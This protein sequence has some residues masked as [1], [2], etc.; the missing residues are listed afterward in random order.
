MVKVKRLIVAC[1]VAFG[2]SGTV[3]IAQDHTGGHGQAGHGAGSSGSG[4]LHNHM[5]KAAGEMR[6]MPMSG[7]VDHDFVSAMRKHHQHGVEMAQ[8]ALRSAKDPEARAFAQRVVTEQKKEIAELD[9]W[10]AKHQPGAATK[11]N[12]GRRPTQ[13]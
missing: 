8:I 4:E 3:A 10:L 6:S 7:D 9:A 1:S 2:V 13:P 11:Q 5:V 12:Q